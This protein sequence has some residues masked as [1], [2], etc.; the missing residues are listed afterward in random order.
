MLSKKG[1]QKSPKEA[2]FEAFWEGVSTNL[3]D[4]AGANVDRVG[5]FALVVGTI[6]LNK[7][8]HLD[9]CTVP[10]SGECN[11]YVGIV[12]FGVGVDDDGVEC[13]GVAK[14]AYDV[15][16]SRIPSLGVSRDGDGHFLW[17]AEIGFAEGSSSERTLGNLH[18]GIIHGGDESVAHRD[19]SLVE[20]DECIAHTHDSPF[21]VLTKTKTDGGREDGSEVGEGAKLG[22]CLL[23]GEGAGVAGDDAVAHDLQGAVLLEDETVHFVFHFAEFRRG[24]NCHND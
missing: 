15:V 8:V 1:V 17:I 12:T 19:H 7:S 14:D 23:L 5:D 22:A 20:T 11:G 24:N 4:I 9:G 16:V 18:S 3:V 2:N 13:G 21:H 10:R 6:A